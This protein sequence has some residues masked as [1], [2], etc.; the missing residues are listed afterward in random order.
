MRTA[1]LSADG[2][3]LGREITLGAF[4]KANRPRTADLA[5]LR[6]ECDTLTASQPSSSVQIQVQDAAAI[7][8]QWD[9]AE[10][11]ER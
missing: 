6:A 2:E 8:A 1:R 4:D 5:W 9:D 7:G 10:P 3:P 11:P